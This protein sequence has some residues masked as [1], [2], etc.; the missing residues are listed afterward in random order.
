[1]GAQAICN[2]VMM[3]LLFWVWLFVGFLAR[4]NVFM[5][6]SLKFNSRQERKKKNE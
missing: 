6:T 1:M 5:Y 2:I 4:R 3:L